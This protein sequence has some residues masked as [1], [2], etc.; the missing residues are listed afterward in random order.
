[1]KGITFETGNIIRFLSEK[2]GMVVQ[3]R[4]KRSAN[5]LPAIKGSGFQF[6]GT[7]L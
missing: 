2:S 4:N 5:T 7:D 6:W 1:M 3:H